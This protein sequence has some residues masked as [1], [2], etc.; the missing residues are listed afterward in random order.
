MPK[1]FYETVVDNFIVSK[2]NTGQ[3]YIPE[4]GIMPHDLNNMEGYFVKMSAADTLI[5]CGNQIMPETYPIT[6]YEGWNMKAYLR[7]TPQ[8]AIVV[9]DDII[10]EIII[11]KDSYGMAYIPIW[12]YNG[13]GNFEPGQGYQIK[14]SSE[15][16][17]IYDAND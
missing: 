17:L 9:L 10:E 7:D 4:F 14:K 16:I 13:I 3:V 1:F 2:S 5:H 6:L 12:N 15:Q 8:D 11:V